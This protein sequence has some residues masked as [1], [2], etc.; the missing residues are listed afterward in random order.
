MIVSVGKDDGSENE[1]KE[2]G[3]G[4]EFGIPLLDVKDN[5]SRVEQ[6]E[7]KEEDVE[8]PSDVINEIVCSKHSRDVGNG[9]ANYR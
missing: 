8:I 3:S 4:D 7:K 2:S 5:H 6:D 1:D 9:E